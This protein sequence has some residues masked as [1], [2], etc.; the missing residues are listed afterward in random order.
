M[1]HGGMLGFCSQELNLIARNCFISTAIQK[2][3][4]EKNRKARKVTE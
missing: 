4:S 3:G 1:N 2:T